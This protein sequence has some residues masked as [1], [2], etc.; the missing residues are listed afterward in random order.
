MKLTVEQISE[1]CEEEIIVRCHDDDETWV[2]SVRAVAAGQLTVNGV[3]EDK[4]YRLKLGDIYYFEV[5]EGSS[6]LYCQK[7]VFTCR[8]KLYEFEAL[9]SGTMLFRCSKS[10]ILNADKIDYVRPSFSGRYEAILDNGEKVIV[11]RQYVSDLK[12]LFGM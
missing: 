2:D 1:K 6:F 12:K 7:Q 9:C 11:S 3:C 4:L 8:Q 10:M 5:V